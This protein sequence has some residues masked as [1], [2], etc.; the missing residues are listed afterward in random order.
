[1][2]WILIKWSSFFWF[3]FFTSFLFSFF[4]PLGAPECIL[5]EVHQI[6][7]RAE[8]ATCLSSTSPSNERIDLDE[9]DLKTLGIDPNKVK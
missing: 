6:I 9:L 4:I 5:D 8:H 1:L 2:W 3:Y 7:D